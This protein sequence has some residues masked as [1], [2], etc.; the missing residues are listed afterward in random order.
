METHSGLVRILGGRHEIVIPDTH[1]HSVFPLVARL[2]RFRSAVII[3]NGVYFSLVHFNLGEESPG[4]F[5]GPIAYQMN[6]VSEEINAIIVSPSNEL[7]EPLYASCDEH[8][9]HVVDDYT[10]PSFGGIFHH[11]DVV[12]VPSSKQIR[13]F[14]RNRQVTR[15]L[16]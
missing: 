6:G 1:Q 16:Y 9:V 13:I 8:Q 11:K 5:I 7:S 14:T 4:K 15:Q 3:S 10:D 2:E 12:A